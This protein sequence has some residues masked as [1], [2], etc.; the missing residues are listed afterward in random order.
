MLNFFPTVEGTAAETSFDSLPLPEIKQQ[1]YAI[2]LIVA[3]RDH[4]P[5]RIDEI[6][7]DIR[8]MQSRIHDLQQEERLLSQ[9]LSVVTP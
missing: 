4:A 5:T 3:V 6:Q 1:G 2:N 9:L 8:D 7:K